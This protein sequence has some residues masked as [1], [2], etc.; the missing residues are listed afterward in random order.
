MERIKSFQVDHTK[1]LPGLY[2]SRVDGDVT[3]FDLRFKKPNSGDLLSNV[4]MHT[5]EH[6]YAT[7]LRNSELSDNII[8]FG[9]MGC[10]TGFY[11]LTRGLSNLEV[12]DLL[13]KTTQ[14]IL[15][16]EGEVFGKSAKECG[17]YKS[18]DLNEGKKEAEKYL[19]VL[20]DVQ[21]LSLAY[22]E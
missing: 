3:T 11:L 12:Y 5:L 16:Y 6:M 13:I 9:P 7:F 8:Y 15:D 19:K 18:L 14:K 21:D 17:N 4:A 2:V 22:E 20:W 1:L 10:Q